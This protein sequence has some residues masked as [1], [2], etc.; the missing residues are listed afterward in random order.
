[1]TGH[2]SFF[3]VEAYGHFVIRRRW[4]VVFLSVALAVLAIAGARYTTFSADYR[5]FFAEDN[6]QMLAFDELQ[7][8]YTKTDTILFI[9]KPPEG[10]VFTAPMLGAIHEL[11]ERAW[12][13][14]H[15]IRVDS[16]TNYQHTR[17]DE[18]HL[19]IDRFSD[20]PA[21]LD[22]AAL[23]EIRGIALNEPTLSGRLVARDG[24]AAGVLVTLQLPNGD[25]TAVATAVRDAEKAANALRAARP[26][27]RVAI[28]GL[29]PVSDTYPA[30]SARDMSQLVPLMYG[31]IVVTMALLLRSVSGTLVTVAGIALASAAAM[32]FSGWA[33]IALTPP[34]AMVPTIVLTVVVADSMHVLVHAFQLMRRGTRHHDAIVDSV[35][36]NFVPVTLTSVTTIIGFLS[37]NFSEA[38]PYRDMGNMAAF[39]VLMA[40][41][42]SLTFVPAA[43]AILPVRVKA[44]PSGR[45]EPLSRVA[46]FVLAHRR[47]LLL[48]FGGVFLVLLALIPRIEVNDRIVENFDE[49]F[50]VR[51]DTE[52]AFDNLT[53]IYQLEFSIGSGETYGIADP[54]YLTRLDAFT[55][56]LRNQ[57]EVVHVSSVTDVIKRISR[58][59]HEND[60]AYYRLPED[61]Q[62]AA[63]FLLAYENSLPYGLSLNHTVDM[64]R[65][66]TRLVATLGRLSTKEMIDIKTRAET[67]LAEHGTRPMQAEGTGVAIM[68]AYLS[69]HNIESMLWGTLFAFLTVSASLILALRNTG[70]GLISIIPNIVPVFMTFG[71]WAVFVGEIATPSSMV[72]AVCLGLLD[73]AT[74]HILMRYARAR[75]QLGLDPKEAMRKALISTGWPLI[76]TSVLMVVG[77]GI[78]ALSPFRMNSD[79]GIM[80]A[81]MLSIGLLMEVIFLPALLASMPSRRRVAIPDG[82]VPSI[83]P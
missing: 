55:N 6:E 5:A 62:T 79:F 8:T 17:V 68:F 80:A 11:T 57:P 41:F 52:F 36:D 10:E 82:A 20:D 65:S 28:T 37:L 27:L 78:L 69:H 19:F 42:L 14:P 34:T 67:W 58:S 22:Q 46:D 45:R 30:A 12:Q 15:S 4:L 18:D 49:S 64:D 1:M 38:P 50:P 60:P 35:I 2:R 29:A 74:V 73:D 3:L 39:G 54:D 53:G 83:A 26:E 9:L 47:K 71:L 7:R 44:R 21:A 24:T 66:A 31:I 40:W 32:G 75:R 70:L 72:A 43:A 13:V 59:M 61:R 51:V 33:G 63:H 23:A 48:G 25:P 81:L 56:W 76:V 77:F 16:L